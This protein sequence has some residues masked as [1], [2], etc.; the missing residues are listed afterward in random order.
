MEQ[1]A[2]RGDMKEKGLSLDS[3]SHRHVYKTDKNFLVCE[4]CGKR[5]L[6]LEQTNEDDLLIGEKRNGVKYTVRKDRHRY[7]FPR[8]WEEFIKL[9]KNREHRFFFLTC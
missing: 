2:L 7:F 1:E 4:I 8:E 6:K 5:I 3:R 9:V